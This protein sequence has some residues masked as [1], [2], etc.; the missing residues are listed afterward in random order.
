[1]QQKTGLLGDWA[2]VDPKQRQQEGRDKASVIRLLPLSAPWNHSPGPTAGLRQQV[3]FSGCEAHPG[4]WTSVTDLASVSAISWTGQMSNKLFGSF[5]ANLHFSPCNRSV[6]VCVL[7][8][9]MH[10]PSYLI[11]VS[12]REEAAW[13]RKGVGLET[14]GELGSS[15]VSVPREDYALHLPPVSEGCA[16]LLARSSEDEVKSQC[17]QYT[18]RTRLI[19]AIVWSHGEGNAD[20]SHCISTVR[21]FWEENR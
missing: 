12:A 18:Q 9:H 14:E 6:S 8:R 11:P 13:S 10:R 3:I 4:T 19:K 2:S 1:M 21:N 15:P 20:N 17:T 5:L 7:N 16:H